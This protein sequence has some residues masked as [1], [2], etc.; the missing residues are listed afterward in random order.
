M[1]ASKDYTKWGSKREKIYILY[2]RNINSMRIKSRIQ[3][4][5]SVLAANKSQEGPTE[6]MTRQAGQDR[7]PPMP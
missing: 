6:D 5:V 1:Y 2:R 3:R 4:H 7:A